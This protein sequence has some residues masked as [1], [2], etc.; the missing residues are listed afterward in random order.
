MICGYIGLPISIPLNVD[1]EQTYVSSTVY[2]QKPVDCAL[3]GDQLIKDRYR[4]WD[5]PPQKKTF[6]PHT[7]RSGVKNIGGGKS[8]FT[9][10][11]ESWGGSHKG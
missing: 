3:A 11:T 6:T 2:I 5:I 1:A 4:E 10:R 8:S 7:N 9:S